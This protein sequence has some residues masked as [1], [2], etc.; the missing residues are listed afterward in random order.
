MKQNQFQFKP[1][2]KV[3]VRDYDSD[4]WRATHYSHCDEL[5]KHHCECSVWEQC[6]PYNE[7]TAHLVGTDKPY[8]KPEPVKWYVDS[9]DGSKK[10]DFT[11]EEFAQFLNEV[12]I[13]SENVTDF[14]VRYVPK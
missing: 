1:F 13:N 9:K 3:L 10:Y 14:R 7:E 5:Q 11:H 4:L 12:V 2:D 6:I 8:K